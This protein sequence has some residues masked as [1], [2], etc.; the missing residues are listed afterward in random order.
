MQ[1]RSSVY[2]PPPAPPRFCPLCGSRVAQTAARCLVCGTDL[3]RAVG[4]LTRAPRRLYPS[5]F[6]LGLFVVLMGIGLLFTLIGSGT[7][8][9][10][11]AVVNLFDTATPTLTFTP[12]PTP[13]P[14]VTPSITPTPT[15]TQEP[16]FEYVVQDGDS[17]L[18][19]ALINE[20]SVDS[21]I[22]LNGLGPDCVIAVGQELMV[23]RP[24]PTPGPDDSRT[25]GGSGGG[26]RGTSLPYPTYVILA[27]DSCLWLV[28]QYDITLDDFMNVNG[29]VDCSTLQEGQ[30]VYIPILQTPVP[31]TTPTPPAT[32]T[33]A[34]PTARPAPGLVQPALGQSFGA[35]A[36][37]TLGWTAAGQLAQDEFYRVTVEDLTC[38]CNRRYITATT[39]T[40]LALPPTLR[41]T[42]A[43]AHIFTWSVELVRQTGVTSD[44]QATYEALG[45]TS[46]VGTFTWTGTAATAP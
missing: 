7:L 27:G 25:T 34:P 12:L 16:P 30:I 35:G 5:P 13:T 15:N 31:S 46:P 22:M 4:R 36:T 1:R 43:T 3:D 14:T 2:S 33:P 26:P 40:S 6:I 41:P 20:V 11:A 28:G 17:C 39:Q 18:L 29:L 42:E 24:S 9:M 44:G 8:P 19:I 45:V 21:I 32:A 37:V 10:P 23:P 38:N